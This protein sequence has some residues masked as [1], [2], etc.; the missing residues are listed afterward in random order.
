[1]V[2]T[3]TATASLQVRMAA[4]ASVSC[5]LSNGVRLADGGTSSTPSMSADDDSKAAS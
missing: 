3:A 5:S 1:M 4:D 2:T